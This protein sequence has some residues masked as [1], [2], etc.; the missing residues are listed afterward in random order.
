MRLL[1]WFNKSA[2]A[3]LDTIDILDLHVPELAFTGIGRLACPNGEDVFDRFPH[4]CAAIRITADPKEL[5]IRGQAAV[6]D[7]HLKAAIREMIKE[8][9][10]PRDLCGVVVRHAEDASAHFN[11]FG[12]ADQR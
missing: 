1:E 6:A 7:S 8:R 10:L 4:H 11:L 3:M 12:L 5:H 9:C 2:D